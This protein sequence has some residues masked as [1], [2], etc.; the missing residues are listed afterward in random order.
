[1]PHETHGL[2]VLGSRPA[3]PSR[4][5]L[6]RVLTRWICCFG[7]WLNPALIRNRF[8]GEWTNSDCAGEPGPCQFTGAV[9]LS[10]LQR[11]SATCLDMRARPRRSVCNEPEPGSYPRRLRRF[12]RAP[13]AT[14]CSGGPSGCTSSGWARSPRSW[15]IMEAGLVSRSWDQPRRGEVRR[16]LRAPVPS[17]HR[18]TR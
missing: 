11:T 9:T 18:S 14:T 8:V 7:T 1:M 4:S 5:R 17:T 2:S 12:S 15:P 3:R 6:R 10:N 13:K 16:D